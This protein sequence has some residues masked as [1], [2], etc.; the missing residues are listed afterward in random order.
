MDPNQAL[1]D[2]L[3]AVVDKDR[4]KLSAACLA[5]GQWTDKGGFLPD[6]SDPKVMAVMGHVLH[7][8]NTAELAAP[9]KMFEEVLDELDQDRGRFSP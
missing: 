1:I 7:A 9:G 3:E 2:L 6:L 8:I 4:D 5:L